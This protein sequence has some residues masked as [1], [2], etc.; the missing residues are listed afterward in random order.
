MALNRIARQRSGF[1]EAKYGLA[2]IRIVPGIGVA[3][4]QERGTG[5]DVDSNGL[6]AAIAGIFLLAGF[7]KGAIGLGLPTV[8]IGLLGLLMAPAQAAAILVVPSLVTNVWQA[9]VGGSFWNL[10]RRLWPVLVGI[11][12]GTFVGAVLLPHDDTGR[13]T[14][15]LGLALALYAALGLVN[16]NLKVPRHAE[17]WLGLVMGAATG[18]TTVATGIFVIPGT[19]YV[20]S[21]QFERDKL[22]QALGL[23]FTVSTITLALALAH[24][25]QI[26]S[27]LAGPSLIALVASLVGMVLGQTVRGR[28]RAETF[29]LWFFVG[30]LLLGAHLALHEFL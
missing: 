28:V 12:L 3:Q 1:A 26:R 30:L 7:V 2:L 9:L 5:A 6:L 22:V 25:G 4:G 16:V 11:C 8:S 24:A 20:Q 23:S 29:R 19:P 18:A 21:L 17:T 27:S 14:M 15:W 13:A 10:V